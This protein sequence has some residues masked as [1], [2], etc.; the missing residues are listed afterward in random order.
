MP[1]PSLV[2]I[3]QAVFLL[4]CRQTDRPTD[5]TERPT[6]AGGYAGVGNYFQPPLL[7][8]GTAPKL[9]TSLSILCLKNKNSVHKHGKQRILAAFL[10]DEFMQVSYKTRYLTLQ[11]F[12]YLTY[13]NIFT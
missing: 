6:H 8:G 3:A 11:C 4:E 9:P 7:G 13:N 1:V 12:R 5:A 10:K 2:L